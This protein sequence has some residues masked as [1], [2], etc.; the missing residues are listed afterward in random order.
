M[1]GEHMRQRTLTLQDIYRKGSR[2]LE[3]ALVPEAS[4]D[5]WLLLSYVAG[6]TKASYYG[7]P[8]REISEREAERYFAFIAERAKR[9]PLQHITGEQEFM[10]YTFQVNEHVLIP[11][12]DT[13]IL[14]EEAIKELRPGARALDLCT[15]SGCILLSLLKTAK[16]RLHIKGIRGVGTDISEEALA[17]AKENAKSLGVQAQFVKGDLFAKTEERFDLIVSNPPYIPTEAIEGLQEEVR[18]FDPRIALD[19]GADGLHFYREIVRQS[20]DHIED[21][22]T[23]MFEIGCEQ[24]E[25]VASLMESAGY[26]RVRVKKD[27]SGLDRVVRGR[28]NREQMYESRRRGNV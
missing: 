6:I 9:V 23:L 17:V 1:T 22:G 12:Q 24:G 13:E 20:I 28:Y 8:D 25:V 4:L 7:D 11:R 26:S 5:A 21:A 3:E 19:G 14:V 15:G 2:I 10:G 18:L 27:L 16:E